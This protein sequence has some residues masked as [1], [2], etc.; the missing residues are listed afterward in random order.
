MCSY[1]EYKCAYDIKLTD[2]RN[3]EIFNLTISDKSMGLFEI[4][5]KSKI[6]RQTG[7][8]L[9]HLKNLTIKF[10]GILSNIHIC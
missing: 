6:A 3:F 5:K 8:I 2:T 10:Y 9:N 7:F 4:M 1:N